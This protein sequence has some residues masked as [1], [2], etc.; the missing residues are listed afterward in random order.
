MLYGYG[1]YFLQQITRG[2][3]A[4]PMPRGLTSPVSGRRRGTAPRGI[5]R[6]KRFLR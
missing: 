6:S 1:P 4:Q 2:D 5:R 3:R